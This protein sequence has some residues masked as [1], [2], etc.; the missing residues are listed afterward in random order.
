MK[1]K[2]KRSLSLLLSICLILSLFAGN[3]YAAG[4]TFPDSVGHWAEDIINTLAEKGIVAGFPDGTV[5][6]DSIITRAEFAALLV[7]YMKIDTEKVGGK[8]AVFSD[9]DGC[10]SAANIKALAIAGIIDTDDYDGSF[11]P[12]E[13]ITRLEI[14]RMMVRSVDKG[15]DAERYAGS[16]G[17]ADD[18]ALA[19]S[20]KGYVYYATRY[21]L[22][23]G[24]PDNTIRPDSESTR[25]EAFALLVRQDAALKKIKSESVPSG[26]GSSYVPAPQ[27]SFTLQESAYTGD[28]INIA[29]TSAYVS[30]VTWSAKKDGLPADFS[31]LFG[32]TL[33][34][35]GG[36]VKVLQTGKLT[37]IATAE[38]SRGVTITCEQTV[39]VYPVVTAA[40]TLPQT[41]HTDT[42]VAVDLVTENLGS[43]TVVWSVTKD[44]SGLDLS[45]ALNG[46]LDQAG[47]TVR[48]L[49]AGAYTL[50]ASI[51]DE[52]G[53]TVTASPSIT[54]YPVVEVT[55][56]LPATAHTDTAVSLDT[57]A[58]NAEGLAI[59]YTLTRNNEAV[60]A[61]D[62]IEGS[63]SGGSVRFKEKGVYALTA[64]VTDATGR[65]FSDTADIAVY[66]VGSAGF[67]L[68]EIFHTD[69][70]VSVEAVFGEIGSHAAKWSL[71]R[72][73]K[74]ISLTEA[75]DGSLSNSG[76]TLRFYEKGAYVL[77]AEF[78]DDGGRTYS[79]T[80]GFTV[81]P[82]PAVSYSLPEYVHTDS[83]IPISTE[84]TNLGGL[85]VEWLVDNTYGFQD[86]FTYVN[87]SLNNEGGTIRF[88]RAGV[89][90]LVARVTDETGRV[91]LFE[92]GSKCEVL[93]VLTIGFELPELAY[94]DTVLDLRTHGNNNVLPVEWSVAHDS[95]SV[96]LTDAVSGNLNAQGG[97]ITL[98]AP[99]EYVLT[100][101]MTDFLGRSYTHDESIH[102][103]PVIQYDFTVPQTV[104]YGTEFAITTGNVQNL[105][106]Y[107]VV[108]TLLKD[109]ALA[110]YTG[111]LGN[112]GG[113]IAIRDTGTFT[114][115][116]SVTDSAGRVTAHSG[117]VTITNTA[118]NAPTVTA[119]Q[120]R[121]VKNGKFLVNIAASSTDPDGDAVTLEYDGMEPDGYY[122]VG[123][124]TIKVRAQDEA[125]AYS[126]WTEKYFTVT[127]ASPTV[128]LTA[129]PTRTVKDGKF[130]VNV[131]AIASDADG[132]PVALEWDGTTADSYYSVGMHTIKVRAR[133]E[134]GAYSEWIEA[135]VT[136]TNASPTVILTATPTR[137]V[138]DGKFLVDISAV[139]ADADGDPTTLE[140]DGRT[141]DDYYAPG[142]NTVKARAK[143]AAG[144]YSTWAS[145]TFTIAS[146][147]PVV[148]VTATPTRTVKDGKFLVNI[149]ATATDAEGDATTLEWADTSADSYY[150]TG[151][152]TIRVRAKDATGMYS[153]W[154]EKTFTVVN[155]APTTPVISRT[156]SSNSVVPGTAVTITA[157]STD[158]DSD[159]FSLVWEGRDAE[160]QD[161]PLGKNT[162]KVKAVDASGA[163]SP[164]AAI[165]F[166]VADSN[167]GGGMTLTGPESVILENG[168]EGATIT[169]Y[170]F[171]VPPVD[172]HSGSDY[173]RVRG[174]NVLTGQ[175]DQLD[176]QTTT[177]G[178]TFTRTLTAGVYS[179]L[180]FYYYTNHNCMYNKSNITYSV[181]YYFE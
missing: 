1:K 87:G 67:Y 18:S 97:K 137:T 128:T 86:W 157:T 139:A 42:A 109:G 12:A 99:G 48:F 140:W 114:L 168:L 132:D 44:G 23:T 28:E 59:A 8:S 9:L 60:D 160:T 122:S 19:A 164:W 83:E 96:L 81:Y 145:Q 22:V 108:W 53:K 50:T 115:T 30:G 16:T 144:A 91:F 167:S 178:I 25:A 138:K 141:A 26:G 179:K 62:Y 173:G 13:P 177:N 146:S 35:S 38:N 110:S 105:G 20:D 63:F 166:F 151:T 17:F 165:V 124:H 162:V 56:S 116:A 34:T 88:K 29:P 78:T 52:L 106:S 98:P 64:S 103:L 158:P 54:A 55:L 113:R 161:Y 134:A 37:L 21:G 131:K 130:L 169:N 77:K 82:V 104:H 24:F 101:S 117:S 95:N 155:S 4:K 76:G 71:T 57:K 102:I 154:L 47:G 153:E 148:T 156:P 61:A 43:N 69:K 147:A 125:G 85:T 73:G 181:E 7:R 133:D 15:E 58:T 107:T 135:I 127:N 45:D 149:S 40:L 112:D 92:V 41:A 5:R 172:G 3:A 176:Y 142:T 89:Y 68:P 119:E 143:D 33:S 84:T 36:K 129:T 126:A 120:T 171:T 51:T 150:A 123:V 72:D 31:G 6:P 39:A 152:H 136:V 14:I 49:S 10:W 70:T 100:A 66:P 2:M 180:E 27:F 159:P 163:E 80:Q 74:E 32:G 93:P 46:E 175:W 111:L 170:T 118:P 11:R 174:Y 79:Y 94:T 90:E 121:T 75:T 65:V